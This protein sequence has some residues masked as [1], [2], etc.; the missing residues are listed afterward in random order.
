MRAGNAIFARKTKTHRYNM[1]KYATLLL[2]GAIVGFSSCGDHENTS[3]TEQIDSMA[4]YRTDTMQAALKAQNDSLINAMAKMRADSAMH[5]GPATMPA[6]AAPPAVSANTHTTKVK[7][8]SSTSNG[9]KSTETKNV[10]PPNT[11]I[12]KEQKAQQDNKF[13]ER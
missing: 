6:N 11:T 4:A 10:N 5:A 13:N 9:T 2:A 1:K 7:T 12:T 8:H 3:T